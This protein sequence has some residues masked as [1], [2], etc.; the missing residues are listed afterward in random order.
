M[1]G[2]NQ[3]YINTDTM[4]EILQIWFDANLIGG[5][6]VTGITARHDCGYNTFVVDLL[7]PNKEKEENANKS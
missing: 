5:S 6:K 3:F 4:M 1:I 7:S 2:N